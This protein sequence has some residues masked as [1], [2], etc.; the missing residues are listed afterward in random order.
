MLLFLGAF[1]VLTL[2]GPYKS[3][4]EFLAGDRSFPWLGI[5]EWAGPVG[6][7]LASVLRALMGGIFAW[8][9]PLW[10]LWRGARLVIL[11]GA[12]WLP[13]G[14]RLPALWLAASVWLAQPDLIFPQPEALDRCGGIGFYVAQAVTRLCGRWGGLVVLS[15][16]LLT[17]L[18]WMAQP[19]LG[20]ALRRSGRVW[21]VFGG[22]LGAVGDLAVLVFRAPVRL[23][24]GIA[25]IWSGV[26]SDIATLRRDAGRRD[27]AAE[28]RGSG[29]TPHRRSERPASREPEDR[30]RPDPQP[31]RVHTAEPKRRPEPTQIEG[32]ESRDGTGRDEPDAP[33]T[34]VPRTVRKASGAT[35]STVTVGGQE[36]FPEE[37]VGIAPSETRQVTMPDISILNPP[38][39]GGETISPE[40]LNAS[41][42]L[43]EGTLRS[44]GVDGVVKD[45]RPGPV[46]TTF[47]Y[48]PATGV[49][50]N[51]IVQRSDDLALAM[52][53]RSIRMEAPIPGK[54]AVGIEIPN[55]VQQIVSMRDVYE[56]AAG[57][58]DKPL[59][60]V[61][62]QDVFGQP[63]AI[64]LASQ[65]HLLVAGSTGS[66]KSVCINA[67]ITSLLMH[68]DPSILRLMLIDPKMLELNAYNDIPH[69]LLPVVTDPKEALRGLK[70]LEAQMDHRYRRLAKHSVR[71]IEGY[72]RKVAEGKVV[73]SDGEVVTEPIPYFVCIVDELADLM[74]QLGQEIEIP[75]TRIA[76]KAR[77]VGIHL[78]LATQRPS[79]DVLTGV[80]KANIPCRIAFR[81]IQKNDSRTILDANGAEQLLGRGDMLYLQ[82]G[83]AQP[84]RVHGAFV[85]IEE[86]EA[87]AEHWRQYKELASH[88]TMAEERDSA[89][90]GQIESDSLFEKAREVIVYAQHGSTS[91]LQRKLGV[92]YARAGRLMDL[93]E[94]AGVVGPFIGSKAR[95]VLMRPDDLQALE[96]AEGD[97]LP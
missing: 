53:A 22:F 62:G 73:G 67:M 52:K 87:I 29:G 59:T 56:S 90:M 64:D 51:A 16:F 42:D 91:M 23:V 11:R 68:C 28:R 38:P 37:A 3:L 60:V 46:V 49:R 50:V 20:P 6:Y 45:V 80:I 71:N 88:I 10:L 31:R 40:A 97:D 17:V 34:I 58:L 94:Q 25:G 84:V 92:G 1:L 74:M 86:C 15:F 63:V 72:N 85:D 7:P 18:I 24:R 12:R 36:D 77:A 21:S 19:W 69:L 9:L 54:A 33:A 47:E 43:L 26:G 41:A 35:V 70:W 14:G 93:L 44:F 13:F 65:P 48:Q 27:R 66:G 75:I 57:K 81:V 76:Q 5:R 55:P 95:E 39:A 79:V 61:L 30:P 82:P 2:L 32:D 78:V 96:A 83:R 89:S 4:S 8:L